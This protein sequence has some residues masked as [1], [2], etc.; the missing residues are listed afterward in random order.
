MSVAHEDSAVSMINLPLC[1]ILGVTE[2]SVSYH[3]PQ[4]QNYPDCK[5]S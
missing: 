1:G 4:N 2:G 3:G 5:K